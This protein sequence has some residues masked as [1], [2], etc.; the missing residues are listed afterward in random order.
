MRHYYAA[1]TTYST[2]VTYETGGYTVHC[3]RNKPDRD[4]WVDRQWDDPDKHRTR[5]S[6]DYRTACKI[7]PELYRQFAQNIDS[8]VMHPNQIKV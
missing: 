7:E 6:I 1:S 4:A 8:I 3:F 5:E 2:D